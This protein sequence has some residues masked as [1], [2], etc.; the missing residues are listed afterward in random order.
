[1]DWRVFSR[2]AL[3]PQQLQQQGWLEEWL[4]RQQYLEQML[5][6]SC[7]RL[8][9]L[10]LLLLAPNE[11]FAKHDLELPPGVAEQAKLLWRRQNLADAKY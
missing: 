7:P 11:R 9:F 1:M 10:S 4:E 6:L 3:E 2:L 8:H 5:K